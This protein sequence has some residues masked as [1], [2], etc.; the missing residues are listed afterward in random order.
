VSQ[1]HGAYV[2]YPSEH[3]CQNI[4]DALALDLAARESDGCIMLD[5]DDA[6]F[7]FG[8]TT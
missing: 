8:A 2:I 7:L 3:G 1:F 6:E 5:V 4:A